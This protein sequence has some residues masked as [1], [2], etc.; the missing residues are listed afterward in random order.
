M[1]AAGG[2]GEDPAALITALAGSGK[3][4]AS[5][6]EDKPVAPEAAVGPDKTETPAATAPKDEPAVVK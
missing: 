6:P 4:S 1:D 2:P 3:S 5:S